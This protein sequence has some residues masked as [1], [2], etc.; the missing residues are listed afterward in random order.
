MYSD[1]WV[2]KNGAVAPTIWIDAIGS[3]TP[4]QL[5]KG[6]NRCKD[7]IFSGNAW[8]P[9]LA[10]FLA[11]IHS[12]T[13]S[14]YDAAFFRCLNK[15]PEGRIET[16]VYRNA[17]YN[18]RIAPDNEARRMHRRF[19]NEADQLDREGRLTL[20]EDELRALPVNSV[21]NTN[22]LA[23]EAYEAKHG[24]ALNPRIQRLKDLAEKMVK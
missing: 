1:K 18:I 6:V 13:E 5:R 9:D 11:L 7:N 23:R 20:P 10:D 16:W 3:L 8:A 4:D 17:S 21:K 14:D 22:D 12:R 2:K 24:K 15:N 19:M